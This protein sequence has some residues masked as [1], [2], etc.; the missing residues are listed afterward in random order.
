MKLEDKL[1]RVKFK[2]DS[3]THLVILSQDKCKKCTKKQCTYVCPAE[4]YKMEDD[5]VI[6]SFEGCLECGTCRIAC[7]E[8][9]NIEWKYP[10]GGYG[11]TFIYG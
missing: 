6:V 5:N 11:V 2:A 10:L 8:F 7:H 9:D 3:N 4:C 1:F